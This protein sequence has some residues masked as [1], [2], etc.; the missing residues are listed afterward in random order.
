M[1]PCCS[2]SAI[3]MSATLSNQIWVKMALLTLW[4]NIIYCSV[5]RLYVHIQ[6]CIHMTH[7]TESWWAAIVCSPWSYA[8][9]WIRIRLVDIC[10]VPEDYTCLKK[11][12]SYI[13]EEEVPSFLPLYWISWQRCLPHE[14]QKWFKDSGTCETSPHTYSKLIRSCFWFDTS[15]YD[16]IWQTLKTF[17]GHCFCFQRGSPELLPVIVFHHGREMTADSSVNRIP[18]TR[19]VHYF[20][21]KNNVWTDKWLQWGTERR[22][23]ASSLAY[24]L[25]H[26]VPD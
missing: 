22:D 21:F 9:S 16:T 1:S 5:N 20:L 14:L 6:V 11:A 3:Q 12:F 2:C 17:G 19:R 24:A 23:T 8:H 26:N 25:T 15:L 13:F 18:Q 10:E 7:K 4:S